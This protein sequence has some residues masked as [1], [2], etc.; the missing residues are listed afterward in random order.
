MKEVQQVGSTR[1]EQDVFVGLPR[2][3][4]VD[5]DNW[6]VRLH[7]GITPGG[8]IIQSRDNADTRYQAKLAELNGFGGF[9]PEVKGFWVRTAAGTMAL[10]SLTVNTDQ[11]TLSNPAGTAGNP[12][13]GLAPT[14]KTAHTW[15]EPQTFQDPIV[16]PGFTGPLTGDS[17][18]THTGPV[19]GNVIG[20]TTG[21][22]VGATDV[23]SKTLLLDDDQIPQAKVAGLSEALAALGVFSGVIWAYGGLIADIPDGWSICDGTNGTPD[24]RDRFIYGC[25]ADA[26]VGVTGGTTTHSHAIT[27]DNSGAHVHGITVDGT[28]L[29]INQMP[30]HNHGSGVCDQGSPTWANHGSIAANPTS[31]D[32]VANDDETGTQEA[33]T[34]TVG[35]GQ[36]HT[37]GASSASS[38]THN[39][40]ASSN[41]VSHIPPYLKLIYIM[42]D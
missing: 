1:E 26:D 31:P 12:I 9:A 30:A 25:A 17:A 16:A 24:L 4:T 27:I 5:T 41:A 2:Q 37:H 19:I 10:R 39:H 36:T 38:G 35:G 18:G 29:T 34:T 6:D 11:L 22:H 14:I 13:F 42:K 40:P 21:N 28:A 33:L 3:L 32:S 15:T 20:N 23:R 8:N 7:D